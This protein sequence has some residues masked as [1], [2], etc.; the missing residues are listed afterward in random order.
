MN[1]V[2]MNFGLR[3]LEDYSICRMEDYNE[4]ENK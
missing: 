4:K 3:F 1:R 2:K